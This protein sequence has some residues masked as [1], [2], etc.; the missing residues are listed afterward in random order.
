MSVSFRTL[1]H[2]IRTSPAT[3]PA[4]LMAWGIPTVLVPTFRFLEDRQRPWQDRLMLSLRDVAAYAVG[5][6]ILLVVTPLV[7]A[8]LGQWDAK[9]L[10]PWGPKAVGLVATAVGSALAAAYSGLGARRFASW[11]TQKLPAKPSTARVGLKPPALPA[12]WVSGQP[13]K[14][15]YP[16]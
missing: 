9:R 13:L 14:P 1:T 16:S 15:Y 2:A 7:Q 8:G 6:G 4:V 5:W 12:Y 11:L 3:Q 10:K